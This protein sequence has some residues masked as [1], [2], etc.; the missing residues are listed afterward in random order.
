MFFLT[1]FAILSHRPSRCGASMRAKC[2]HME[3]QCWDRARC[4]W[5]VRVPRPGLHASARVP[6]PS[7]TWLLDGVG[8]IFQ[9]WGDSTACH[10]QHLAVDRQREQHFIGPQLCFLWHPTDS[11]AWSWGRSVRSSVLHYGATPGDW[12]HPLGI[13]ARL[14]T[15]QVLWAITL[16][17]VAPSGLHPSATWPAAERTYPPIYRQ[18]SDPVSEHQSVTSP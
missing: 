12:R 7:G 4:R 14:C 6:L 5:P 18:V 15:L 1:C 16:P 11:E 8:H 3:P 2:A 13:Q 10:P 17:A 9:S